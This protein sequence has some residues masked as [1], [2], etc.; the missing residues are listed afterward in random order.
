MLYYVGN[1]QTCVYS[2]FCS[3][4]QFIG[5]SCQL[6]ISSWMSEQYMITCM[7]T[8]TDPFS[9][10]KPACSSVFFSL[11]MGNSFLSVAKSKNLQSPLTPQFLHIP[12]LNHQQIL[13]A[14]SGKASTFNRL[15][16]PVL[17]TW[18]KPWSPLGYCSS[19]QLV[20]VPAP[21]HSATRV[22][23]SSNKSQVTSCHASAQNLPKP[24]CLKVKSKL[25]TMIHMKLHCLIQC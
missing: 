13:S 20:P 1:F 5:S 24:S 23:S 9:L 14:L 7:N 2:P 15:P 8:L 16:F 21:P 12:H 11:V 4:E 19:F 22:W 17:S 25:P 3:P 18:S 10:S 6:S